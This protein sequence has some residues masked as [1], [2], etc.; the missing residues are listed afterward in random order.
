[1]TTKAEALLEV[2]IE[3]VKARAQAGRDLFVDATGLAD[4][5]LTAQGRGRTT[6]HKVAIYSTMDGTT[7]IVTTDM[8]A[9]KLKPKN[10][11]KAF[12]IDPP[13]GKQYVTDEVTGFPRLVNPGA[14]KCLLHP[15]H[16]DR[17]WLDGIG[18]AGKF[19]MNPTGGKPGGKENIPNEYEQR[20]HMERSH[21]QEWKTIQEAKVERDRQEDRAL[22]RAQME[23]MTTLAERS[24]RTS[25][26]GD[27]LRRPVGR[28]PI[29]RKEA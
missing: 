6:E 23:A 2:E 19:C 28:P 10:G 20:L 3:E 13:P 24:S 9:K 29:N 4:D 1:M 17:E 5:G 27:A 16:P 21:R 25:E 18:L 26:S 22:Q 8:L 11:A 7:S 12:A 14:R 15:E